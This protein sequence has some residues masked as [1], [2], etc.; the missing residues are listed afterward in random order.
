MW[1]VCS[2][3]F[4][5]WGGF[6]N[7]WECGTLWHYLDSEQ[8]ASALWRFGAGGLAASLAF[9]HQIPLNYNDQK[10][11]QTLTISHGTGVPNLWA[12]DTLCQISGSVR[13]EIKCTVS[14]VWLNHLETTSPTPDLWKNC[15]PWNQSLVPKMLGI[16]CLGGLESEKNAFLGHLSYVNNSNKY[17]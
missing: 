14:V 11:L 5:L 8:S 6:H 12:E 15:L 2:E 13:L 7:S 9:T 17:S 10:L 4:L 3:V 1:K 16:H